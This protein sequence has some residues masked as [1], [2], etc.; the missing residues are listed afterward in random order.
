[1]VLFVE[2]LGQRWLLRS[3]RSIPQNYDSAYQ[4][5]DVGR[6]IVHIYGHKLPPETGIVELTHHTPHLSLLFITLPLT[7]TLWKWNKGNMVECNVTGSISILRLFI[8]VI[9]YE[10]FERLDSVK[11]ANSLNWGSVRLNNLE[12]YSWSMFGTRPLKQLQ[13]EEGKIRMIKRRQ[14][15]EH[16]LAGSNFIS[17]VLPYFFGSVKNSLFY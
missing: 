7:V 12:L 10:N 8:D 14:L 6:W 1:M 5:R 11:E 17:L 16:I 4:E 2:A 9:W 3:D 15:Y 13:N